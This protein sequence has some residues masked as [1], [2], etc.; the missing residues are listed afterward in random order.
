NTLDE[1]LRRAAQYSSIANEGIKL[2][3]REGKELSVVFEYVDV[4]RRSER[5]QIEF[6]VAGLIRACRQISHRHLTAQLVR[7]VPRRKVT[8]ELRA[9]F[10]GEVRFGAHADEAIFSS[11]IRDIAIPSGDPYL[12]ELLL[13]YCEEALNQQKA[14]LRSFAQ[15]VENAIA[16]LMPHGKAH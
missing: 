7:F 14:R 5:H 2:T 16:V 12:N 6:W 15:D 1:A 8:P 4:A 9:F 13:Q 3:L 11:S 10:G